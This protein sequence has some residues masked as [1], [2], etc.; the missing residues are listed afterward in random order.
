MIVTAMASCHEGFDLETLVVIP[1]RT[2]Q[3][4]PS[5]DLRAGGRRIKLRGMEEHNR[6]CFI[7]KSCLPKLCLSAGTWR[8]RLLH[9]GSIVVQ[10]FSWCARLDPIYTF[11]HETIW[12]TVY[13]VE[14]FVV[15]SLT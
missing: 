9:T 1:S 3:M 7:G 8:R 15:G 12:D 2:R 14:K 11:L 6:C 5:I 13:L 4:H 10:R